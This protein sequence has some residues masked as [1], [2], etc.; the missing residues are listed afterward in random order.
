M[1]AADHSLNNL[2]GRQVKQTSQSRQSYV[3]GAKT[4]EHQPTATVSGG[5]AAVCMYLCVEKSK[6][7]DIRSA[8]GIATKTEA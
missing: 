8:T 2:L 3:A 5:E 7:K 4:G 1:C 6:K